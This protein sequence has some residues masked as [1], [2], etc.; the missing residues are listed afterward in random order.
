MIEKRRMEQRKE[1]ELKRKDGPKPKAK[2]KPPPKKSRCPKKK[3][4]PANVR[5]KF[6]DR[7]GGPILIFVYVCYFCFTA[8][9]L[10]PKGLEVVIYLFYIAFLGGIWVVVTTMFIMDRI[11]GIS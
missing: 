7:L 10:S 1:R 9:W 3:L 6:I 5:L 2:L 4:A 11:W 8:V